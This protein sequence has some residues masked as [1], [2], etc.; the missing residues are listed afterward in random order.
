MTIIINN[1]L[2]RK[3]RFS[4]FFDNISITLIINRNLTLIL[5]N[6]DINNKKSLKINSILK[7]RIK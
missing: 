6:F 3:T 7:K 1:N 2:S 5:I 4:I